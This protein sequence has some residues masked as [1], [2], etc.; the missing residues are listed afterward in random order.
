M[1]FLVPLSNAY[2]ESEAVKNTEWIQWDKAMLIDRCSHCTTVS[3]AYMIVKVKL[4]L[5]SCPEG[6]S[7]SLSTKVV[8]NENL[9]L[10]HVHRCN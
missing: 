1:I 5:M 6:H 8:K 4:V 7:V 9:S 3:Q 2:Q 10:F